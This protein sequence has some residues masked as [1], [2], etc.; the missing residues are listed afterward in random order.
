M[1][2]SVSTAGRDERARITDT[3]PGE[4]GGK[5]AAAASWSHLCLIMEGDRPLDGGARY[6]LVGVDQVLIG[7]GLERVAVR[8]RHDGGDLLRVQVQNR[9]ASEEHAILKRAPSGWK[10]EDL[11]SKNGTF[12]N[13]DRVGGD[14]VVQAGDV[15]QVGRAF[16]TLRDSVLSGSVDF[17]KNL[18]SAEA[19]S[20]SVP[21]L[22]TLVPTLAVR[23][24][25]ASVVARGLNPICIIG[26]TGSGKEV[27]AKALHAFSGRSGR[28]VAVNC[29]ELT[30]SL[31]EGQL[32]GFTRGAY[33]GADRADPGLVRSAEGGTLFL[34]E[35]PDLPL[36]MQAKLLR[37]LQEGEVLSLGAARVHK[38]DIR[39]IA[40]SQQALGDLV[41]SGRFRRDLKA[42]LEGHVVQLPPLNERR[43]DFG[44]LTAT[45]LRRLGV[46]ERDGV[47]MPSKAVL[48]IL[49]YSWPENVREFQN[50]LAEALQFA[51]G[52]VLDAA[53]FPEPD[54][55][56]SAGDPHGR[57][58]LSEED[59][60]LRNELM[61]QM[62][63]H[64]G[65][66]TEVASELKMHRGQ[67][68]RTLLRFGLKASSFRR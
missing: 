51:Q 68:Y 4:T 22:P 67:V 48:R 23:L 44:L 17:A 38:V 40:A 64:E 43:E 1:S 29:P 41:A 57:S 24:Q 45:L 55:S 42:R 62:Q 8:K 65:N 39:V 27:L 66:V 28:L 53:R 19:D 60:V 58:D 47:R 6:S 21:G 25:D 50:R 12:V 13:G 52:G 7:G 59:R 32:F 10:L 2:R 63:R 30:P 36:E 46:S 3:S 31:V 49:G 14:R 61:E 11:G 9:L 56:I 54:G 16:F 5:R 35:I 18:T 20:Q 33:T 37:V 34:D 26:P 15:I